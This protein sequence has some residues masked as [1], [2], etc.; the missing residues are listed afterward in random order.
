M[1]IGLRDSSALLRLMITNSKG[2]TDLYL[3]LCVRSSLF[4]NTYEMVNTNS[5][6]K[7]FFIN[8]L[9]YLWYCLICGWS[10][11]RR[12]V[13]D[14]QLDVL[15]SGITPALYEI[16]RKFLRTKDLLRSN[17]SY[18][19]IRLFQDPRVQMRGEGKKKKKTA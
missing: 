8:C 3:L 18:F 19:L 2:V 5:I 7:Y 10:Q 17:L 12:A 1:I 6:D 16:Q 4:C 15:K 9:T 11:Q 14:T 13:S